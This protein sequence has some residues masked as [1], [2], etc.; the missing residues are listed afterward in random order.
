MRTRL[1]LLIPLAVLVVGCSGAGTRD[2]ENLLGNLMSDSPRARS[3]AERSLAE[4]GR[5][6]VK[7]LSNLVTNTDIEKTFNDYKFRKDPKQYLSRN[8]PK[9][10]RIPAARAL[11]VIAAKA[12]LARS[13]AETAAKPL[14]DVLKKDPRE[15]RDLRI[16][17]AK[18]LGYFS[19]LSDPANDLI[20]LFREDD[21]ELVEAATDALARNALRSVYRLVLPEE[22][23]VARAEKDWNRL[24]ERIRSTDDE[25]RL[26]TVRELAAS[27]D[28]RAPPLLLECLAQDKSKD[29]RYAAFVH[30][31]ALKDA[32]A[33]IHEAVERYAVSTHCLRL[34]LRDVL[35]FGEKLQAQVPKSFTKDD[36]SRVVLLAAQ[37]LRESKR[38]V[39]GR[40]L[41]R[42]KAA[43]DRCQE[44]LLADA[45]NRSLD[46]GARSDAI[47]ALVL[48]P[49]DKGHETKKDCMATVLRVLFPAEK[50]DETPRMRLM[51][52]VFHTLVAGQDRDEALTGLLGD[53]DERVRAKRAAAS[54][55]ATSKTETATA[56]LKKAMGEDDSV[57]QLIAAQA[58][59]R[60]SGDLDALRYLV[61]LLSD[62]D[63]KIRVPAADALG[64][65]ERESV[66]TVLPIA[67]PAL[68]RELTASLQRA[69]ELAQWDVPLEALRRKPDLTS[70]ERSEVTRLE[71]AIED[72][73][74]KSG[75]RREEKYVAWGLTTGLGRIAGQ[76]G[77]ERAAPA[78]DGIIE[79]AQ[80]HYEDVRRV[81]VWSLGNFK[82]ET[83]AIGPLAKALRD[84]DETVRWYAASALERHE[85]AALPTLVALLGNPAV[86]ASAATSLGRIGDA[87]S[88]KP[89]CDHLASAQGETQA[90]IVW[91]IG[92]LLKRHPSSSHAARARQALEAARNA[93]D[94]EVARL[95]RYA[96]T[97]AP[98]KP[99]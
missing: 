83:K 66:A 23:P 47:D 31:L 9:E 69:R 74:K 17:A 24:D 56:A 95:A 59:W 58:L 36:D 81:A 73:R 49:R 1:P 45:T 53:P 15:P 10:L 82:G 99:D 37:F 5:A 86:A 57:V 11:G 41:D 7:P 30:C 55:L 50:S 78:L 21:Q 6:F 38:D 84:P 76:L 18:A 93:A 42:V 39:V 28:N 14:L 98:A 79:A 94:P 62:K 34:A 77:A 8:D 52:M 27:G 54:V 20:L 19:Q 61:E 35:G 97:K 13:E 88:L 25:V 63:A 60:R 92:E 4:H 44:R 75:A 87:E 43:T 70:Q 2:I 65:L 96:L 46:S 29:V 64:A 16:E 90:E 71:A 72:A 51:A 48:L 80:C 67:L 3:R 12:S 85:A 26:D 68:V 22:P 32:C 33:L 40:F 89:L 91:G